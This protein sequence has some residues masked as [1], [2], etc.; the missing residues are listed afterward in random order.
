ML[1][2][3]GNNTNIP[4][5]YLAMSLICDETLACENCNDCRKLKKINIVIL[6]DLMVKIIL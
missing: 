3:I 6:F 5:T 2:L 1:L 4:L